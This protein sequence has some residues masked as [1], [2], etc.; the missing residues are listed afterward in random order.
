M[1]RSSLR[2]FSVVGAL[3]LAAVALSHELI[4]LVA[5]G[6]GDAYATAMSES[7]HDQYW[8]SFLLIV[9]SV[10]GLLIVIAGLQFRRLRGLAAAMETGT[11]RVGEA[12][13]GHY[14]AKLW[15]LWRRLALWVV[16]AYLVQ[17]NIET[18]GV[19]A[20]APGIDILARE[21]GIS[22]PILLAVSL[23]V[24]AVGALVAWRRQVL[25]ARIGARTGVRLRPSRSLKRPMLGSQGARSTLEGRRNGVRAPPRPGYA[26]A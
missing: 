18:V 21:Q 14:L 19:G 10:T 26:P 16:V 7:G 8:T 1:A 11:V 6:T 24:A 20:S 25:L 3:A 2:S 4:Y 12:E 9:A 5:H 22:L 13:V 15:A 17:E 23:V